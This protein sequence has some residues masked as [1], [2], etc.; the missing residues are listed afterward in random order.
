MSVHVRFRVGDENFALPVGQVLEVAELGQLAP[1]PGRCRRRSSASATCA[2]RC[3]PSSTSPCVLGTAHARPGARLVDRRGGRP[4]GRARHR[5]GDGRRRTAGTD[6]G[7]RLAVHRRLDARRRRARGRRR[8]RRRLRRGPGTAHDRGSTPSSS[9]SSGTRRPGVSITWSR[10][11]WRSRPG[12]AAPDAVDSLFRDAHTIKGAPPGCSGSRRSMCSR[13][14]WR[15]SSTG[16]ADGGEFPAELIDPLLRAADSLRRHVVGGGEEDADLLRGARRQPPPDRPTRPRALPPLPD[17]ARAPGR[18]PLDPRA[19]REARPAARSGRRDGAAPAAARACDRAR[20]AA[21]GRVARRTSWTSATACSASFRKRRS[22]C[23]RFRSSSIT[24]PFPRA[25]RDIAAARGTRGRAGRHRCRDRAR[26]RHPRRDLRADH[27]LLRNAVAHGIETPASASAP[28]SQ[29]AGRVELQA[30]SSAAGS[31]RSRSP[32]TAAACPR[33]F[34]REAAETGDRSSTCSPRPGFSTA[35]EVSDARRP[36]GRA[37]RR[38]GAGR[39]ARRRASRIESSPGAGTV[40]L[41]L[42]STLALLRRA[43]WSSAAGR[44]SACRSPASRRSSRSTSTLSLA[45]RPGD[46]AA[47]PLGSARRPGRSVGGAGAAARPAA[48]ALIVALRPAGRRRLRRLIG[49]EQEVVVKSLGPLL[50]RSRGYL[51]A[52]ILGDGRIALLLDPGVPDAAP[53]RARRGHRGRRSRP[54]GPRRR[55]WSWTTSSP[56]ASS[57]AASSRRRATASR[58]HATAARRSTLLDEEAGIEP[59]RDGHR[60]ARDGRHRAVAGDPRGRRPRRRFP[61]SIVTT[62]GDEEDRRRGLE[63][64]ADAYIV[65]RSF[66]QQALLDTVGQLVGRAEA[67]AGAPP[68]VLICEDSRDVRAGRSGASSSEGDELEVVGVCA[69]AEEALAAPRR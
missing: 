22:R 69:T 48:P 8:R 6:A 15:R 55:C 33:R 2:G 21:G 24:G 13:T 10:R 3:C 52:A 40:T 44:S 1:V 47:R 64:G 30:P 57:S 67:A 61:S 34:S 26:P 51:G 56:C 9:R 23:A 31:S 37:R 36:R 60:D 54:S 7:G 17:A 35:R 4:A 5:S 29:P 18:A 32:T 16:R 11:C 63:A 58:P 43:R 68:R 46:R 25:V 19:G 27:P 14:R 28:A 12:D 39:V 65:K 38:Q 66:D 59:R 49:E 20:A 62:R 45:G 41:L 53:A 50:A 42:P